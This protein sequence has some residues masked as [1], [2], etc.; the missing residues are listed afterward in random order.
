MQKILILLLAVIIAMP[1]QAQ[2]RKKAKKALPVKVVVVEEETPAEKMFKSMLPSTAKVMFIDSVVVEKTDF[3]KHLPFNNGECQIKNSKDIIETETSVNTT[4]FLNNFVS[5]YFFADGDTINGTRLFSVD[6][7]G[8]SWSKPQQIHEIDS[9]YFNQNYPV[10]LNDGMTLLFAAQGEHSLGGYDIFMTLYDNES[11]QFYKPENYG[12]PFNSTAN[13]Y[14]VLF[15][16]FNE[17]GWLV[18]DRYLPEDKV[19]IYT[20]VPTTTR[21]SYG[22]NEVSHEELTSLG[23]LT[24]ISNTWNLEDR[25]K[26]LAEYQN[27]IKQQESHTKHHITFPINDNTVYHSVKDF[28]SSDS[29]R[30]F[31]QLQE[32]K[33][34]LDAIEKKIENL[35]TEYQQAEGKSKEQLRSKIL[36]SESKCSLLKKDIASTMKKIRETENQ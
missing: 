26:K 31:S 30:L 35:R 6:H 17:W 8:E 27:A 7:L 14:M 21:E 36:S 9:S 16:E 19:C 29:R 11:G 23:R 15:D 10:L 1:L 18:S 32:M 28:K 34:D 12:L 4:I 22:E 20:F 2:K 25:E 13:D 24:S 3:Y 5:R 33:S